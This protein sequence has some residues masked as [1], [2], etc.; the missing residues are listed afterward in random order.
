[1]SPTRSRTTSQQIRL[2]SRPDGAAGITTLDAVVASA[3]MT[4]AAALA[5]LPEQIFAADPE[6]RAE[7]RALWDAAGLD[8]HGTNV[9]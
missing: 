5:P 9:F 8:D 4:A 3:D 1:M 2:H 7:M 6:F